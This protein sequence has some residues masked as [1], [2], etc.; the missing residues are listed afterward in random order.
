MNQL[1]HPIIYEKGVVYLD[2]I[3][4]WADTLEEMEENLKFICDAMAAAGLK[5]NGEKSNFLTKKLEILGHWVETGYLKPDSD[6]LRWIKVEC[7]SVPEVR[8]L[9]G[10]LS[11]FRKFVPKNSVR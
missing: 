3:I 4:L 7:S 11:Y 2:D 6:K 10:A 8:S 1:I 5:L 9:L